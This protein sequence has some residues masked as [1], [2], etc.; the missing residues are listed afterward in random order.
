MKKITFLAMLMASYIT[1]SQIILSEDFEGST[2]LPETWVNDDI[3]GAG[4]SWVIDSG[5]DAPYYPADNGYFDTYTEIYGN[6][7]WF[8]SANN[9]AN[10][11]VAEELALT[12]PAF[13]CSGLSSV[14]LSFSNWFLGDE[15]TVG[16]STAGA[17]FVE[18]SNDGGTSWTTVTS[19]GGQTYGENII[20]ITDEV[21]SSSSS[22]VRF[23]WTGNYSYFWAIDNIIVQQPEGSAPD[24]CTNM[25]PANEATEVEIVLSNNDLKMIYFS[26]DAATTG[27]P[28]TSYNWYFGTT[29]DNVSNLVSGFDGTAENSGIT[30][31]DTADT[32]WQTNT[33]YYWKVASINTAGI[34]ESSVY[35]FTTG[36][37][38]PLGIEDISVDTFSVS[39][40][41]VKDI[42]T[43]N[44]STVFDTIKVFNQ[45]GQL[46]IK[47]NSKLMD[48]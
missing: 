4:D 36:S 34:T 39:P 37:T 48:G 33:T 9:G 22:H 46:I 1:N 24:V 16:T 40:N 12:S 13:D 20:D 2:S 42:I 17:G 41:P 14:V 27:D 26:W 43:I 45:L 7:A 31:G 15:V 3:A 18:V 6:Y 47:S 28:A 38:N 11:E 44:S 35:S 5:V 21:G 10:N 19:F 25:S 32:G 29:A 23:R 8:D 30:W